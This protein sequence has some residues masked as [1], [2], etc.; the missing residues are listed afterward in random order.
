MVGLNGKA[1]PDGGHVEP[2]RKS[3]IIK[4][5]MFLS[6]LCFLVLA[7]GGAANGGAISSYPFAKWLF[8]TL[9]GD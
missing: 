8:E 6:Q 3:F 5:D 4:N 7:T 1:A 9:S 2:A